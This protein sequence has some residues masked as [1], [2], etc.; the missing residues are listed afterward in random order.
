[1]SERRTST[2]I[3][4]AALAQNDDAKKQ[5]SG[6]NS[7]D[8]ISDDDGF[9]DSADDAQRTESES[10]EEYGHRP[11]KKQKLAPSAGKRGKPATN[12]Q[13]RGKK[14]QKACV[15][16]EMP[17]D[18]LFEIF[19]RCPPQ[20]LISLSRTSHVFRTHLLS[21]ASRGI[22]KAAR[23]HADGPPVGPGMTE[24]QWAHLLYGKAKC[25]SCGAPNIQ[26]VDFGLQRRSCTRCLKYNLVV[27]SRF[28]TCF[29]DVDP[30]ILDL[31]RYTH[32]G[33]HSHGHASSSCWYWRAD[34]ETVVAELAGLD[35]D[36]ALR[37]SGARKKKSAFIAERTALIEAIEKHAQLC[38]TWLDGAVSRREKE[39]Q[40]AVEKRRND[41]KAR[42]IALG[43]SE[44]D[45]VSI[46]YE[47]AVSQAAPLTDRGWKMIQSQLEA[48]VRDA[49]D[50]RLMAERQALVAKRRNIVVQL[51]DEYKRSL[52]P[53][54][55]RS[56]PRLY[57]LFKEPAF[58]S[59]LDCAD[60]IEITTAHFDAAVQALPEIVL[61]IQATRTAEMMDL[62]KDEPTPT[63]QTPDQEPGEILPHPHSPES[64]LAV[65]VCEQKC[66]GSRSSLRISFIGSQAAMAHQCKPPFTYHNNDTAPLKTVLQ[67]S[68]RGISA[69]C[70]LVKLAGLDPEHA[71]CAE[72]DQVD[73]RFTCLACPVRKAG[74]QFIQTAYPW[75]AAVTHFVYTSAA[76]ASPQWQSDP[77]FT[78]RAKR[79]EGVDTT[80]SWACNHCAHHLEKCETRAK[81]LE[82]V[83]T[84]HAIAEPAAPKDFFRLSDLDRTPTNVAAGAAAVTEYHCLAC[85]NTKRLFI[86]D[87]VQQHLKDKHKITSP[88]EDRD[89]RKAPKA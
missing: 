30:S 17:L 71:T 35:R 43:Y 77:I 41:I 27:T 75:R 34:I 36:I 84:S 50:R 16:S 25:Q 7:K 65:F 19:G 29:P 49:K 72:M 13:Y 8:S 31:L 20:D 83:R 88:I 89:W 82:H 70:A 51:Y 64:A 76:H 9:E 60:D 68:Q 87:G 66:T 62:L 38:A 69:A 67:L 48:V 56:L 37:V 63:S 22:W 33:G 14:G 4:A 42:F 81:V 12:V 28:K 32:I 24:Q 54:Q 39:R 73:A 3:L 79:A 57:D 23:E 47:S 53:D 15:L 2:R 44:R 21:D 58:K 1:M 61:S 18:I 6:G 46:E 59:V 86:L 55:W 11:T 10:D 80:L 40:D 45:V 52:V 5:G 78:D 74:N 26:R 85:P